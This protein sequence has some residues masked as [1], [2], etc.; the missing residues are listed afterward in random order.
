MTHADANRLA[1]KLHAPP[2]P[3][4]PS[5]PR[6]RGMS[7]NEREYAA[8][9]EH[10]RLVGDL[11]HWWGP[12]PITLK[13]AHDLRYTPDFAAAGAGMDGFHLIEVKGTKDGRPYYRDDGARIKPKLAAKLFPWPVYVAWKVDGQWREELVRA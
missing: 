7:K 8:Y 6:R 1:R 10:R 12:E 11:Y 9:L 5:V 4:P 13:L 3:K 2:I